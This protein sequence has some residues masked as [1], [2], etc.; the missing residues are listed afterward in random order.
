MTWKNRIWK[1]NKLQGVRF[2]ITEIPE[3]KGATK[4]FRAKF[5]PKF[6]VKYLEKCTLLV[7]TYSGFNKGLEKQYL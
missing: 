6:D 7:N 5:E 2:K 1:R 4:Q 3:G